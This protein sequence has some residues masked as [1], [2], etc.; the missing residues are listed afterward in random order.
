MGSRYIFNDRYRHGGCRTPYATAATVFTTSCSFMLK[1]TGDIVRLFIVGDRRA[2]RCADRDLKHLRQPCASSSAS[3][4]DSPFSRFDRLADNVQPRGKLSCVKPFCLRRV[5]DFQTACFFTSLR[6]NIYYHAPLRKQRYNNKLRQTP[7]A[8]KLSF[9]SE[10][11]KSK[12]GR[13]L[14]LAL[15][16]HKNDHEAR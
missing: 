11:C 10:I 7:W 5:S 6:Q 8:L 13:R 3:G 4:T 1:L 12:R 9:F 2:G 16:A 15:F 14:V